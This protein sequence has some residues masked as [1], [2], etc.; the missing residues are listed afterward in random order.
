MHPI[1]ERRP[2]ASA[3][4]LV[5]RHPSIFIDVLRSASAT[6][7]RRRRA[8]QRD[9]RADCARRA[10]LAVCSPCVLLHAGPPP[11]A[12]RGRSRRRRP[13]DV[14]PRRKQ[15]TGYEYRRVSTDSLWQKGYFEHVLR[16]DE[17]MPDA[18]KYILAN[19]VRGGLCTEPADYPFEGSLV[20]SKEQLNDLWA[21]SGTV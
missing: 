19:P 6:G 4:L 3:D 17:A 12:G 2:T 18:A 8:C 14:R 13:G 10:R 20:W 11:P 7:I 5:R 16:D 1:D 21:D 9:A 15:R